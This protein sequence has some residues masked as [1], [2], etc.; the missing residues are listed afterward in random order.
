MELRPDQ[1]IITGGSQ[2]R[3]ILGP[4]LAQIV[5]TL[6]P[7]SAPISE[8]MGL[9]MTTPAELPNLLTAVCMALH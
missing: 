2:A 1:A 9:G 6:S 4:A 8:S 7:A 5:S 3:R